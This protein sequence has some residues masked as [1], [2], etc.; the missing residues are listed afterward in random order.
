M[1]INDIT[2]KARGAIYTIINELGPGLLES[3]Y[4]AALKIELDEMG[5]KVESQV[6]IP[7]YYKG[8]DL[9]L[10]FRIDLMV[11]DILIIELKSVE[12]IQNVHL[13]QLLT[14]LK[15]TGKPVGLLVN[16]NTDDINKNIKRLVN[17]KIDTL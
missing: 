13:K 9:G 3:V 8:I 11:E 16:F 2:Y 10:G 1:L 5:L 4:E 7:V 14:Y 12:A 6:P 15:L 17:G